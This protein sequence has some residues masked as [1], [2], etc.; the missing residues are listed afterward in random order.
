ME[1]RIHTNFSGRNFTQIRNEAVQDKK[2]S[3]KARGILVYLASLPS[4]WIIHKS[5]IIGHSTDKKDSF[6]SGW[7]ELKKAGY[8]KG[9][10]N[11]RKGKYSG[12]T[13]IV[14]D[15]PSVELP[16]PDFPV[17][18]N[19]DYGKSS[20]TNTYYTN[21]DN[22]NTFDTIIDTADFLKSYNKVF[23]TEK[24]VLIFTSFGSFLK[25]K[26]FLDIIFQAKKSVEKRASLPKKTVHIYGEIWG[27]EI[28]KKAIGFIRKMK[29]G[30]HKEQPIK[31]LEAYWN[32]TMTTFWEDVYRMVEDQGFTRVDN[33]HHNNCLELEETFF[34]LKQNFTSKKEWEEEREKFIYDTQNE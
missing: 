16:E 14:T 6:N 32:K 24:T 8:I 23:L 33:L 34:E 13:W 20:T 4:D 26:K 18:G 15:D 9:F 30:A 7:D 25:A 10:P 2:L 27:E 11:R 31:N 21:T 1:Q 19:P 29:E 22:T 12:Y 3:W 28:E 17:S 5:E